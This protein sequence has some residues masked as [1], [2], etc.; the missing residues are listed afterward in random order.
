VA[1]RVVEDFLTLESGAP[2]EEEETAAVLTDPMAY[3]LGEVIRQD[4]SLYVGGQ[5]VATSRRDLFQ[6]GVLGTRLPAR[7]ERDLVIEGH[8]TTQESLS[9]GEQ[10]LPVVY[11]SLR[12]PEGAGRGVAA[13]PLAAPQ[14]GLRRRVAEVDEVILLGTVATLLLLGA[15]AVRTA[16]RMSDPIRRLVEATEKMAAGDLRARVSG[17]SAEEIGTL[18]DGFNRMAESLEAQRADLEGRRRYIETILENATTGVAAVDHRGSIRT[19]NPAAR[20][21]LGLRSAR[22]GDS[23]LSL[24]E[25]SAGLDFLAAGLRDSLEGS[26]ERIETEGE[27]ETGGSGERRR[28]RAVVLRLEE[29]GTP[30]AGRILLVEDVT[31]TVR[32]ERLAAWAEMARRIAHEIKNPLT[33]VSLVVE[34]LRLLQENEDPALLAALPGALD[35]IA[36]QVHELRQISA[37]FSAYARLPE[38]R[39][40]PT[41]LGAFVR[42]LVGPYAAAPPEGVAIHCEVDEGLPPVGVDERVLRR[43]VINLLENALHALDERPG[44]VEV[45][46][47]ADPDREGWLRLRIRDE[48]RGMDAETLDRLF[49]PYFSTRDAGTG[50]GLPIARRAV[51]QH[52]GELSAESEPGR[53]TTMTLRLPPAA[54]RE[55]GSVGD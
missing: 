11:G 1:R 54:P 12:L 17:R 53:G 46:V 37:E 28:L 47:D 15:I 5:L 45:L 16:R 20:Q 7:V 51:E 55:P 52:G 43:A 29:S 30:T 9:L 18:M 34:H 24:L 19:L 41:D 39:P 10:Q 21:M 26:G 36:G 38:M 42:E 44:R 2:E 4:L 13:I 25:H 50:L 32:S 14:G 27:R 48:G 33:P 23:L 40:E 35:T 22:E 49:E 6:A 31:E 8:T 3:W